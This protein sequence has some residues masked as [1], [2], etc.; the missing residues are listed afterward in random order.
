MAFFPWEGGGE[1]VV[2]GGKVRACS[3]TP[4]RRR[5]GYRWPIAPR[6]PTG[7]SACKCS[8]GSMQCNPALVNGGVLAHVSKA[9]RRIRARVRK[10]FG[11]RYGNVVS[12]PNARSASGRRRKTVTDPPKKWCHGSK[13]SGLLPDSERSIA[14]S[15]SAGSA[16]QRV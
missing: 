2:R 5:R 14:T 12:G 6:L 15:L 7:I 13:P 16:S 8:H 9:S 10:R 1:D 4:S 3:S 11:N